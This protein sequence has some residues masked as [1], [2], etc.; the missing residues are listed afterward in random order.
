[1]RPAT[2]HLIERLC[3]RPRCRLALM[4]IGVSSLVTLT[5]STAADSSRTGRRLERATYAP[6]TAAMITPATPKMIKTSH[7]ELRISLVG[8][9]GRPRTR[10]SCPDP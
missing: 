3:Q 5:C 9:S 8:S 6:T 4:L 2:E 7:S 1:M 10:R